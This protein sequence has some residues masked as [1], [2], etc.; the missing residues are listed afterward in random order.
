M[1]RA[2]AGVAVAALLISSC[3]SNDEQLSADDDLSGQAP[4]ESAVL[5]TVSGGQIDANSLEGTDTILWY[6]APW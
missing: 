4:S 2:L 5:N 1:R 3:A 6:W